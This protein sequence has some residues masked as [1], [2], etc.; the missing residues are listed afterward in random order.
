MAVLFLCVKTAPKPSGF[1]AVI[2]DLML[3]TLG[4]F[5]A[6]CIVEA[7]ES[8]HQIA[9]DAANAFEADIVFGSA[10][11]GAAVAD[12]AVVA[13]VKPK[14]GRFVLCSYGPST[15]FLFLRI[16]PVASHCL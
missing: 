11:V 16:C 13:A 8:A 12:D 4:F 6:L 2:L 9:G 10:A 15:Q 5:L 1:G 7:I 14:L 3:N